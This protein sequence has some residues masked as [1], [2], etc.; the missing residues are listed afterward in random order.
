MNARPKRRWY[1]FSLRT[2]LIGILIAAVSLTI[3]RRV[4]Y[5]LRLRAA[6]FALEAA[7]LDL[8]LHLD[9]NRKVPGTVPT[10]EL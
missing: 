9:D 8:R 7:A 10:M 5:Q 1:Q 3:V 2:M 6:E 4:N